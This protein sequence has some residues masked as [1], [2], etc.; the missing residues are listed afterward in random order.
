MNSIELNKLS[1]ENSLINENFYA[2]DKIIKIMIM[3]SKGSGKTSFLSSILNKLNNCNYDNI[4]HSKPTLSLEI[5][6]KICKFNNSLINL[7]LWDSN[8]Q[9]LLSPVI[10]SN[11]LI[12]LA[13]L[14]IC[15][16]FIII[17]DN[18]SDYSIKFSINQIENIIKHSLNFNILIVTNNKSK[19]II[20]NKI[21]DFAQK[22]SFRVINFNDFDLCN[23]EEYLAVSY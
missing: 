15:H 19:P 11:Y 23:M 22:F 7:E 21:I 9:I 18:T 13:Y 6:K 3:G 4:L 2:F 12:N 8:E 20:N 17:C 5:R 1:P 16:N 14:K 10:K